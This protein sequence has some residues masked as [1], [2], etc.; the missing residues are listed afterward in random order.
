MVR[1]CKVITYHLHLS[2]LFLE[3]KDTIRCLLISPNYCMNGQR[4]HSH[5]DGLFLL[6]HLAPVL[7]AWTFNSLCSNRRQA[8]KNS[9]IEKGQTGMYR[10]LQELCDFTTMPIYECISLPKENWTGK[11]SVHPV[12]PSRRKKGAKQEGG[13]QSQL[14]NESAWEKVVPEPKP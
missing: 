5:F 1:R 10:H 14:H 7:P 6:S 8:E 13:L 2:W 3:M 4:A 9:S 11:T 12:F